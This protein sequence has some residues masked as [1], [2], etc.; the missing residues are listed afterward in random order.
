VLSLAASYL[1]G[2]SFNLIPDKNY[3]ESIY[4]VPLPPAPRN[5]KKRIGVIPKIRH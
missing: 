5:L 4:V 1:G 2:S 3:S